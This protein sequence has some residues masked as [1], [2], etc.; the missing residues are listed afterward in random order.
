MTRPVNLETYRLLHDGKAIECL[1]CHMVSWHRED[2]AQHYCA[3][4]DR[5]HDDPDWDDL[6]KLTGGIPFA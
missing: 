4:C 2:V 3:A 5:F 6:A 1:V